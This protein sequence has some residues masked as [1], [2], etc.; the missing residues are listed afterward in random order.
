MNRAIDLVQDVKF[1]S[2]KLPKGTFWPYDIENPDDTRPFVEEFDYTLTYESLGFK[3]NEQLQNLWLT[4][5]VD[6]K[7]DLLL[8]TLFKRSQD[9]APKTEHKS[10]LPPVPLVWEKGDNE[11]GYLATV[12]DDMKNLMKINGG[13]RV[14][15]FA[16]LVSDDL[17]KYGPQGPEREYFERQII[18]WSNGSDMS[19]PSS[20]SDTAVQPIAVL[21]T[22]EEGSAEDAESQ[23]S[24]GSDDNSPVRA[25]QASKFPSPHY[26]PSTP[27]TGKALPG[28]EWQSDGIDTDCIFPE[29]T[30]FTPINV[31]QDSPKPLREVKMFKRSARPPSDRKPLHENWRQNQKNDPLGQQEDSG[32]SI[33]ESPEQSSKAEKSEEEDEGRSE[34][35][36]DEGSD[37][38][39]NS[40]MSSLD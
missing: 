35:E 14:A 33:D 17:K 30:A 6:E 11:E 15:G 29:N 22:I 8:W 16:N 31:S 1:R 9:G 18:R 34:E 28:E 13:R 23:R 39:S 32:S 21:E 4:M 36:D 24:F 26:S 7:R 5:A 27:K 10:K 40:S 25:A 19:Q 20:G 38:S 3:D 2:E 12:I 37:S